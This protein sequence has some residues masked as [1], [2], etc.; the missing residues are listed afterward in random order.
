MSDKKDIKCPFCEDHI[1]E[2]GTCDCCEFTPTD[3]NRVHIF[4]V[5]N[6]PMGSHLPD[7]E[8]VKMTEECLLKPSDADTIFDELGNSGGFFP[9][10]TVI[11]LGGEDDLKRFITKLNN[12]SIMKA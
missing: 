3:P 11:Y 1:L 8:V 10:S 9:G 4:L 5:C 12:A 2:E 6:G 7:I